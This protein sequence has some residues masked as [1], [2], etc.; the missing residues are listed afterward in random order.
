MLITDAKIEY[1][2]A[3]SFV[4]ETLTVLFNSVPL[5]I[6]ALRFTVIFTVKMSPEVRLP[7]M[8]EVF[9]PETGVGDEVMKVTLAG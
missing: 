8:N 5:L 9:E 3:D 6:S 1:L 7:M 2:P 4:Y